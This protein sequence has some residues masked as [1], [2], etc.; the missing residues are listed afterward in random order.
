M[1]N[2][3]K[4]CKNKNVLIFFLISIVLLFSLLI[5][6]NEYNNKEIV[7]IKI[8][9]AIFPEGNFFIIFD[10]IYKEKSILIIN[11]LYQDI[12]D[13][14]ISEKNETEDLIYNIKSFLNI[15]NEIQLISKIKNNNEITNINIR[16]NKK[17][18][19]KKEPVI[20]E[21]NNNLKLKITM[22]FETDLFIDRLELQNKIKFYKM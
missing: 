4:I 2:I 14:N 1:E 8:E 12:R 5:K 17:E 16:I 18:I 11:N 7:N 19:K 15:E 21:I 6:K 20:F 3:K 13:F 10:Y 22:F 9:E